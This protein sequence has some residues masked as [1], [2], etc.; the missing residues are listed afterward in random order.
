M[1]LVTRDVAVVTGAGSGIGRVVAR[2]LLDAGWSVALAGRR[3]ETL[4]ETADG[5]DAALVVPTDVADPVSVTELFAA[6][7]GEWGRVDLLVNNAGMFGPVGEVDEIPVE[8]WLSAVAVNLTGAFLCAREA[9]G[10]DEGAGAPRRADHQQRVDLRAHPAAGQRGLHRDE[11][12]DDGAD[13]VDCRWTGAR[14]TSPA[15]RSTSATP[16]RT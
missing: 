9:V 5:A 6:V 10:V 3:S 16:P 7:R 15:G 11:A 2:A 13:E 1:R 14:T 4:E 12:R 8:G